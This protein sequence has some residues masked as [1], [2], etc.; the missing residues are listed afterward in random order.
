MLIRPARLADVDAVLPMVRAINQLHAGWDDAKYGLAL[1][2]GKAYEPWLRKR[3][4]DPD[5]VF[6]VAESEDH[7][8]VG[9]LIGVRDSDFGLYT[10]AEHG[11]I[12]DV[13][14]DPAHRGGAGRALVRA[15]IDRFAELGLP[16]VRLETAWANDDAR[17]L[18]RSLG[19]RE[20]VVTMIRAEAEARD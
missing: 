1:D 16:Q 5:A 9:Y 13:W 4:T 14:I 6:L 11:F 19:F 7:R 15:A 3:A 20:A 2:P 17:R 8:I 18:F 12:H 10:H